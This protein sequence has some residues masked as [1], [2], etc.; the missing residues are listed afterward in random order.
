ML[1]DKVITI[2]GKQY[3]PKISAFLVEKNIKNSVGLP[4]SYES[5]RQ[6]VNG[7]AYNEEIILAITELLKIEKSKKITIKKVISNI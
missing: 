4:H 5:I 7:V 6:V 1:K 2:L 3:A